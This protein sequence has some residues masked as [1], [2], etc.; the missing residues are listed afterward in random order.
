MY[1]LYACI[2]ISVQEHLPVRPSLHKF[3]K[4]QPPSQRDDSVIKEMDH[5][6]MAAHGGMAHAPESFHHSHD[7]VA[8]SSAATSLQWLV[9]SHLLASKAQCPMPN[10]HQRSRSSLLLHT[11]RAPG[12]KPLLHVTSPEYDAGCNVNATGVKWVLFPRIKDHG[13]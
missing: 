2:H 13:H 1:V 9:L 7:P 10:A 4:S 5:G 8:K 12:A 6:G 11:D 3:T